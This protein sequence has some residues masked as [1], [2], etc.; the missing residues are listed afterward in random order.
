MQI[1]EEWRK[2]TKAELMERLAEECEEQSNT[3]DVLYDVRTAKRKLEAENSQLRVERDRARDRSRM[4]ESASDT[5]K[6]AANAFKFA[7]ER[8]VERIGA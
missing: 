4:F 7:F 5:H 3:L 2:M 1:C 8:L 6:A